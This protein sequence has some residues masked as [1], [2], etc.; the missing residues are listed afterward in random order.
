MDKLLL[1]FQQLRRQKLFNYGVPFVVFVVG[2]SFVLREFT[3]LRYEFRKS[4]ALDPSELKTIG[5][6]KKDPS[7]IT[8][9]KIYEK[10]Q[11]EIDLDNWTQVRG[12][13]PWEDMSEFEKLKQENL[14]KKQAAR[15][16]QPESQHI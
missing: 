10:T 7:E 14:S 4:E 3:T 1:R 12:P 11:K 5:I 13:R 9:E 16:A 8:L 6:E 15:L 2:S